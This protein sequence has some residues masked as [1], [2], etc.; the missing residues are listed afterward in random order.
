MNGIE[1]FLQLPLTAQAAAICFVTCTASLLVLLLVAPQRNCFFF[2]WQPEIRFLALLIFP[3]LLIVWPV[4]LY[5]WFL[6]SRGIGPDDLDSFE[7]D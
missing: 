5:A 1:L 3:A 2:R 4:V 7:D 6:K